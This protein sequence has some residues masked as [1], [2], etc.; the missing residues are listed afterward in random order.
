M[1]LLHSSGAAERGPR[2]PLGPAFVVNYAADSHAAVLRSAARMRPAQAR[3]EE[4]ARAALAENKTGMAMT[5]TSAPVHAQHHRR[6]AAPAEDGD[7]A[8]KHLR[9]LTRSQT[10]LRQLRRGEETK[11]A[12]LMDRAVAH[13]SLAAASSPCG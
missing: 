2:R 5:R 8:R 3:E 4:E 11:E 9:M 13:Y 10:V 7:A 1:D 6:G 12:R